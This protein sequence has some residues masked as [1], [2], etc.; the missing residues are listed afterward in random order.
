[1]S[2]PASGGDKFF[3]EHLFIVLNHIAHLEQRQVFVKYR[4]LITLIIYVEQS[5]CQFLIKI[6]SF[7][8]YYF[9][10]N[11]VDNS[12]LSGVLYTILSSLSSPA[13]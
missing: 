5:F 9:R 13:A 3:I 4:S 1:M 7:L 12:Y 2:L 6:V 10:Q 11:G 8:I